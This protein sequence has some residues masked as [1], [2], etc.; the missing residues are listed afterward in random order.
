[1]SARPE[2]SR[3]SAGGP[4]PGR[5]P[6]DRDGLD[7][8]D[9]FVI[10]VVEDEPDTLE[11]VS[12]LLEGEDVSVL[13][14]RHGREALDLLEEGA[15]PA[16]ILLDLRMPVMDGW[17]FCRQ[18]GADPRFAEIPVAIVTASASIAVPVRA[19]DAGLF[20]KPVNYA[21]LLALVERLRN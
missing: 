9:D 11:A 19:R 14:A 5:G 6:A 16:L 4:G 10:L 17:E 1:M 13:R 18:Q 12:E 7:R 8:E 20:V 21:R 15:R 2:H 3:H